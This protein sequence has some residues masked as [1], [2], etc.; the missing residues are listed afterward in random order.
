M[1]LVFVAGVVLTIIGYLYLSQIIA[2]RRGLLW[3]LSIF[4]IPPVAAVYS[5]AY[6][7]NAKPAVIGIFVGV[8]VTALSL[9]LGAGSDITTRLE[10]KGYGDELAAVSNSARALGFYVYGYQDSPSLAAV[11]RDEEAAKTRGNKDLIQR[12]VEPKK[13]D[14][15]VLSVVK[16]AKNRVE[17]RP[18]VRYEQKVKEALEPKSFKARSVTRADSY[19]GHRVRISMSSGVQ[20]QA[21]LVK[22]EGDELVLKREAFDGFVSYKIRISEVSQMYVELPDRK[23]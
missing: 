1:F 20:R 23:V 21:V 13:A 15:K 5:V 7:K 14:S 19:L 9:V 10:S 18:Q 6:W 8:A 2:D 17:R 3:G 4:V 16:R 12:K 22:R 11:I